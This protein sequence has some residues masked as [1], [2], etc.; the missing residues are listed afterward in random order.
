MNT[1]E[2][3]AL[4]ITREQQQVKQQ[5]VNNVNNTEGGEVEG[6]VK[7]GKNSAMKEEVPV[8]EYSDVTIESRGILVSLKITYK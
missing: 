1:W 3:A 4:K 7:N 5:P 6:K 8:L 2:L